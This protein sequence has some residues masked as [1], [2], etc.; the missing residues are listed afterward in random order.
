V[1]AILFLLALAFPLAAAAQD[2]AKPARKRPA[3]VIAHTRPTPQQIREFDTLEKKEEKAQEKKIR[4]RS[5]NSKTV[6][7]PSPK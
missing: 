4:G 2:A 6:R 3:H 1:R 5:P 7:A